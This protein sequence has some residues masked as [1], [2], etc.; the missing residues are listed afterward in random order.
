M[1]K[2]VHRHEDGEWLIW[3]QDVGY[4]TDPG[5]PWS[6]QISQALRFAS[7]ADAMF[8]ADNLVNS[9]SV[10]GGYKVFAISPDQEL[11][12]L[13]RVYHHDRVLA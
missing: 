6:Q 12:S 11:I 9:K 10:M 4:L 3:L 5:Y 7:Q 1:T 13:L 8:I 2:L